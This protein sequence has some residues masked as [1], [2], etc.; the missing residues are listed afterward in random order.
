MNSRVSHNAML[1]GWDFVTGKQAEAVL[2]NDKPLYFS[3]KHRFTVLT[4]TGFSGL[5]CTFTILVCLC[6]NKVAFCVVTNLNII[7]KPSGK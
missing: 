1:P 6:K 5:L 7:N 4:V 2:S 3:R